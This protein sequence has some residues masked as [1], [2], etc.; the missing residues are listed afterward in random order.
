MNRTTIGTLT[1]PF[2]EMVQDYISCHGYWE[3]RD[4]Y[5]G[6]HGIPEWQFRIFAGRA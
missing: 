1:F 5:V 3:A 4:Y 2:S 6:R